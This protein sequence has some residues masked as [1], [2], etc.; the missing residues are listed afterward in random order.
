MTP[1]RLLIGLL[2]LA[3]ALVDLVA[4]SAIKS[5]PW[6]LNSSWNNPAALVV[7][8]LVISQVSLLA[9]WT[10]F[11]KT[12]FPWRLL[13]T[14]V[15][16]TVWAE[17]L[18]KPTDSPTHEI[19]VSTWC[20]HF[21][22][23][24]GAVISM[25]LAARRMGFTIGTLPGPEATANGDSRRPVQFSLGYLLS[26]LTVLALVL[27]WARYTVDFQALVDYVDGRLFAVSVTFALGNAVLA[28]AAVWTALGRKGTRYL[29][30]CL[31][32]A[33][34]FLVHAWTRRFAHLTLEALFCLLC[35]GWLLGSLGVF[36]MAGY[37]LCRP[38]EYRRR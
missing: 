16:I 15:A 13:V 4:C 33:A 27:G 2:L 34:V 10:G 17:V 29:G 24:T 7:A 23:Q 21:W 37:R 28:I 19:V 35:L 31:S 26:L 32:T 22:V 25:I 11:G 3:T 36:R 20:F 18:A 8:S 5:W 12:S 1:A 30:L 14:V 9:L 6:L 38:D